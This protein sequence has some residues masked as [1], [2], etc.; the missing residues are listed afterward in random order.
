MP[1]LQCK[2]CNYEFEKEETPKRCPYCSA[3][4]TIVP[5]KTAQDWVD[6]SEF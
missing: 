4:G 1:K 5:Y 3:E 6:E 2:K